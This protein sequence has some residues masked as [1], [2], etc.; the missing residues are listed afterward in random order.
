M[1]AVIVG[2]G[3]QGRVVLEMLRSAGRYDEIVFADDD[4]SL[5]GKKIEGAE[6]IG[7][8]QTL[9]EQDQTGVCVIVALG[10][11]V[12]RLDLAAALS[13]AG[14]PFTTARHPSAVVM[15]SASLGRGSTVAAGAV[16]NTGAQLGEHVL[17]NTS[18]VIE[19][20][21]VLG[22]G[23]TVCPGALVGGR[24][25]IG[26]GAFIG[27]GA[28][29]LQRLSVGAGAVVAAGAV[30]TKDVPERVLVRGV[31]AREVQPIDEGFDWSRLL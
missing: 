21:A 10:N 3:A 22:H 11:P 1:K 6:V 20:D 29:V 8:W 25:T 18:A 31:P 19:H 30:V 4:N 2:G 16:I 23:A 12:R 26:R 27:S 15:S 14:I 17:V 24:T 7:P 5:R 28:I 9:R 13:T